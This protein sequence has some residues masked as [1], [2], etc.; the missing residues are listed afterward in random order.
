MNNSLLSSKSYTKKR[1]KDS[2]C[3]LHDLSFFQD[4]QITDSVESF[5]DV[6]GSQIEFV[7]NDPVSSPHRL[8]QNSFLEDEFSV[9]VGG[10]ATHVLLQVCVFVVVDAN[11]YVA[12]TFC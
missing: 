4:V 1:K 5:K 3:P 9:A 2:Y 6:G 12:R 10:V 11:T 8:H 7:K